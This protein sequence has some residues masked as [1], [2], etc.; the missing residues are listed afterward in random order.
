MNGLT[1]KNTRIERGLTLEKAAELTHIR[2]SYLQAIEE[3]RFADLPSMVQGRGF[4]RLYA[5]FL[6]FDPDEFLPRQQTDVMPAEPAP[7]QPP[8]KGTT[9]PENVEGVPQTEPPDDKKTVQAPPAG[10]TPLGKKPRRRFQVNLKPEK[11]PESPAERSTESAAP[12]APR[13]A[14]DDVFREIGKTLRVQRE[15]ISLPLDK[16]GDFTHIPVHYLEAMEDGN[17]DRLPSLAQA[18]GLLNNYAGFLDLDADALLVH[19]A[20]GLQT[21]RQEMLAVEEAAPDKKKKVQFVKNLPLRNLLTMDMLII[22]GLAVIIVA[23]LV[24][25]AVSILTSQNVAPTSTVSESISEVLLSTATSTPLP[26]ETATPTIGPTSVLEQTKLPTQEDA[27][28]NPVA[29]EPVVLPAVTTTPGSNAVNPVQLLL[30]AREQVYIRVIVDGGTQFNGRAIPG[31]PYSFSG[32]T[33]IELITGN[34]GALQANFNNTDMGILGN[35]GQVID[36]IFT[37]NG[38]ATPTPIPSNTP[39][40]TA[41]ASKTPR[42][43]N[44]YPPSHTPNPTRTPL[45]TVTPKPTSTPKPTAT[46]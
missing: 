20:E 25:G 14:S 34:A 21:R 16:V 4:I 17:F 23:S 38:A 9:E 1:L 7:E 10:E 8:A 28:P 39:T 6:G 35:T 46:P 3:D 15:R 31:T 18:R 2:E 24:W 30:V 44:T 41:T 45:H 42:P 11:P 26:A 37:L 13:K 5:G 29:T 12:A 19:Y 43:S 27:N 40:I 32:A 22:V 36:L 33:Q